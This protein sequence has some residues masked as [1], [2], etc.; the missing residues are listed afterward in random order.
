MQRRRTLV[1]AEQSS[2]IPA[3]LTQLAHT[4]PLQDAEAGQLLAYLATVPTREPV[5]A[6]AIPWWRSW[7]WPPRRC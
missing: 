7:P 4:D 3:A 6:A 5:V 1:P 2:S